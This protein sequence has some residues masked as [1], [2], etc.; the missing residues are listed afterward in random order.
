MLFP[1]RPRSLLTAL[2]LCASSA[3]TTTARA[4]DA[5]DL[6]AVLEEHVVTAASQ[7][8]ERKQT[9]P[10][11]TSVI[12]AE[13]I[14][15]YGIRRLNEALNFLSLGV[16]TTNPWHGVD[17]GA[18]G[19]LTTA[20]YGDHFLLLV[21][22]HT[23]NEPYGGVASFDQGLGVPIELI[24]HIEVVL[25]P[26][27]VLYGNN[28]MLGVI[29]VV[30]KR[31]KDYRGVHLVADSELFSWGKVGVGVGTEISFF[32]RPVELTAHVEYQRQEGPS[33]TWAPQTYGADSITGEPKRYGP[34]PGTGVWGGTATRSRWQNVPGAHLR[35]VSGNLDVAVHASAFE[36]SAAY[37]DGVVFYAGD[38]DSPVDKELERWA[39]VD[40]KYRFPVSSIVDLR[41]RV[42]A[43]GYQYRSFNRSHA[44]EDCFDGQTNGCDKTLRATSKW[45]G[46]E[47]RGTFDWLKNG[48]FVSMLG[49]DAR[50]E[51]ITARL[52]ANGLEGVGADATE[53]KVD[54]SYLRLGT[55]T[56]HTATPWRWLALNAGARVDVAEGFPAA[57]SPRAS[58]AIMPWRGAT[59]KAIY[60]Q[61]FRAPSSYERF[62]ADTYVLQNQAL[63][64]ERAYSVEGSFEQELGTH[65]VL[66]GVFRN[67]W[68]NLVE[69]DPLSTRE[70]EDAR[71]AGVDLA[72]GALQYRNSGRIESV[73]YNAAVS[74]VVA[75]RFRYGLNVTGAYARQ[76]DATG[77][78]QPV[79]VTP[80]IFGNARASYDLGGSLPTLAIAAQFG[81]RRPAD[82]AFDSGFTPPPYAPASLELR[83]AVSGPMPLVPGLSYRVTASY[84][85]QDVGPYVV[86]PVQS[87]DFAQAPTLNPVDRFRAG[88]GLQYVWAP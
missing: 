83:G 76:F 9:A 5:S 23:V 72:D 54:V 13:D 58:A 57:T 27:A 34:G 40:A 82:R 87:G 75:Q 74:G 17:I 11:T 3:V 73:G 35:V 16:F 6:E 63:A 80:S 1:S 64:A 43:D 42:Y 36:R 59:T 68:T 67:L 56:Q 39:S 50:Y 31:A 84:A 49:T 48:H 15:R 45:A 7:T 51:R 86:G 24:D 55:Y 78:G 66:F 38:F 53:G 22:G 65:R 47:L 12:T 14:Q 61:A 37:L 77:A 81:G 71:A 19:V 46:T 88:L 10:A 28:A 60:S 69:L 21:D 30:T 25:G 52:H 85:F 33:H 26:G 41:T 29:N 62:M 44:A 8:A 4:D 70:V 32:G 20:D 18:R 2:A 79:T